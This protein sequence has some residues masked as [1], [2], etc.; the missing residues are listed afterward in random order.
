[1]DA[2]D[3]ARR[4]ASPAQFRIAARLGDT[5]AAELFRVRRR[6]LRVVEFVNNIKALS[7][8]WR[9]V[10]SQISNLPLLS[11]GGTARVVMQ[12]AAGREVEANLPFFIS[13]TLLRQGLTDYTFEAGFPRLNYATQSNDY[14]GKPAA[15]GGVRH[16]LYDWL[17]LE[18]HGEA[19]AGLLNA[20]TGLVASLASWGVVS[21]AGSASRFDERFGYQAYASFDTNLWGVT[22]HAGSQ[23]TFGAYNDLSSAISRYLPLQASVLGSFLQGT[24]AASVSSRPPKALDT[25]SVGIPLPFDKSSLNFSFIRLDMYDR[26]RSEIVNVSYSRPII[27]DA[28]VHVTTFTDLTDSKNSGI[29]AGISVPL[30]NRSREQRREQ[31]RRP[32]QRLRR[33][34]QDHAAR[35]RQLRLARP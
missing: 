14:L 12:D 21:V 8:R 25:I 26:K 19:G 32:H 3:P 34:C 16:G 7:R 5:A 4:P 6:S 35:A 31:R 11:G 15:S 17:T 23:R 22:I 24:S 27:W 30:V 10:P 1:M 33:Y 9:P 20:G 13:P 28:T 2:A 18:A 29:F